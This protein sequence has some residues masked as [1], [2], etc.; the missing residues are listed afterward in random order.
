M[1][2]ASPVKERP[3]L[4][5]GPMVR[6]IWNGEKTQ[7]RRVFKLPASCSWYGELG[8]EKDGWFID[9]NH[10]NGWWHVEEQGGK[11][12]PYGSVGDRLWVR[13]TWATDLHNDQDSP[14]RIQQLCEA[15]GYRVAPGHPAGPIW[16]QANGAVRRWGDCHDVRGRWRSSIHMP[17]WASRL[18]LE[19]T[20]VRVERLQDIS[21][22][23]AIA[24]GVRPLPLQSGDDPS[25]WWEVEPGKHQARTAVGAFRSLWRSINGMDSWS[26]N[27]WVWVIEFD[28]K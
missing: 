3:I 28:A 23:D 15:A 2:E 13:E 7:T 9:K 4:F 19:I 18:T 11:T 6:A 12:C 5:S 20:D 1:A 17:R 16:Y 26:D 8:G 14:R 24:E 27:P 10:P 21:E 22:A 25:A